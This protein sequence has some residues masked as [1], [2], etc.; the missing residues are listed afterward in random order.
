MPPQNTAGFDKRVNW[1]RNV[2][3]EL[4]NHTVQSLPHAFLQMVPSTVPR[5]RPSVHTT[6]GRRMA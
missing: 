2:G 6:K 5:P 4:Y 3:V 1:A